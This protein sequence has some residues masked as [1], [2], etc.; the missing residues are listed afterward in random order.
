MM[1]SVSL[2]WIIPGSFDGSQ[3]LC[4][5]SL[6]PYN[7]HRNLRA[8]WS[9][10]RR[11]KAQNT[12]LSGENRSTWCLPVRIRQTPPVRFQLFLCLHNLRHDASNFS[13]KY[14]ESSRHNTLRAPRIQ[15]GQIVVGVPLG[16]KSTPVKTWRSSHAERSDRHAAGSLSEEARGQAQWRHRRSRKLLHGSNRKS[17]WSRRFRRVL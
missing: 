6:A 10:L 13:R 2:C 4:F 9:N 14:R 15:S 11:P 8:A 7:L 16:E 17:N 12:G 3:E 1:A 5:L